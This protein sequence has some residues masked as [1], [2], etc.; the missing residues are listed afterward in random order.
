MAPV[1]DVVV[2]AFSGTG[3]VMI[4]AEADYSTL[5]VANIKARPCP[6]LPCFH[7][8]IPHEI[9]RKLP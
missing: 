8:E 3:Y 4:A 5:T 1:W 7:E 6:T 9:A 2:S